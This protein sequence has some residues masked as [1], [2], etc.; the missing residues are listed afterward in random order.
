MRTIVAIGIAG[1]LGA[2]ARYGLD[3]VVSRRRTLRDHV[4]AALLEAEVVVTVGLLAHES[5]TRDH[6][7]SQ[8]QRSSLET[9]T[10]LWSSPSVLR[11]IPTLTY[12]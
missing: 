4:V 3:G 10:N 9:R 12:S 6:K 2:L 1:V 5:H 8:L 7:A 11:P